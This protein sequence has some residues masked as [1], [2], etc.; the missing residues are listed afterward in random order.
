MSI[1]KIS[2]FTIKTLLIAIIYILGISLFLV[3]SSIFLMDISIISEFLFPNLGNPLSVKLIELNML[4]FVGFLIVFSYPSKEYLSDLRKAFKNKKLVYFY[5]LIMN[6]L[7]FSP[8]VILSAIFLFLLE[9]TSYSLSFAPVIPL[10][11][12]LIF[13]I[14]INGYSLNYE[15]AHKYLN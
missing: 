10:I 11:G 15:R 9:N 4:L 3:V 2:L 5:G 6:I 14:F 8:I 13:S 7:Y 1:K 12:F